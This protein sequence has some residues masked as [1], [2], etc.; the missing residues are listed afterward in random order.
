VCNNST[1][2]LLVTIGVIYGDTRGTGTLTFQDEKVKN[3]LLPAIHRGEGS[4]VFEFCS[5]QTNRQTVGL[6]Q[7]ITPTDRVRVE[8]G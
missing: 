5:G 1:V 6:K 2:Y 7:P 4:F 3:L 8:S